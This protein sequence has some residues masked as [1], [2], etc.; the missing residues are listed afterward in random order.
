LF[1]F[2]G[3]QRAQVSDMQADDQDDFDDDFDSIEEKSK[4]QLKREMHELQE[5]GEALVKL[6]DKELKKIPL[7][8]ELVDPIMLARR[9]T[10][11]SGKR[12]QLQYIGKLM[13]R[14]DVAPLQQAYDDLKNGQRN[15]A[16]KH[17][18]V[19]KLRDALVSGDNTA[20]ESAFNLYP[21]IE[22]QQLTQLIRQAQKEK[23]LG[24]PAASAKKIFQLL[25]EHQKVVIDPD[26]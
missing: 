17:Q 26:E 24:K 7:P 22:R 8:E 5:L 4:S 18:Q 6:S 11:N 15:A 23:E 12:R 19:E 25:W 9:I 2:L 10:A 1:S 14:V 3:P 16:R 20:L 13:R 21:T